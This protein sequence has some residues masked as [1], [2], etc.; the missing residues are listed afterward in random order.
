MNSIMKKIVFTFVM[1][2]LFWNMSRAQSEF[3]TTLHFETAKEVLSD[4]A[5]SHLKSIIDRWEG[6]DVYIEGHTDNRGTVKSNQ[7]LAEQRVAEVKA[8]LLKQ[9]INDKRIETKALGENQPLLPNTTAQNRAKNRRVVIHLKPSASMQAERVAKQQALINKRLLAMVDEESNHYTIQQSNQVQRI[10]ARQGTMVTIPARAFDVPVGT[11][12]NVKI[13]EVY[14]EADMVL[15]NLATI[16]NGKPLATGGMIK[17]E[18]FVGEKQI[19]LQKGKALEVAVPTDNPTSEMQLFDMESTTAGQTNWVNPQPLEIRREL[20]AEYID[21]EVRRNIKYEDFPLRGARPTFSGNLKPVDSVKI[22]KWKQ[23]KEAIANL[24]RNSHL[25]Y[26]NKNTLK[27]KKRI[28]IRPFDST[29][30]AA[31]IHKIVD[32]KDHK[33]QREKKRIARYYKNHKKYRN[34]LAA[35][36]QYKNWGANKDSIGH[37]NFQK[38][39][40]ARDIRAMNNY[41]QYLKNDEVITHWAAVYGL[42]KKAYQNWNAP[43]ISLER[44]EVL[45]QKAIKERD[46]FAI[47]LFGTEAY[48]EKFA[49]AIYQTTSLKEAYLAH[50]KYKSRLVDKDKAAELGMTVEEYYIYKNQKQALEEK[51]AYVFQLSNLGSFI[52][53]DYF[54]RMAPQELLVQATL[55]MP[56]Q[57]GATRTMMIFNNYKTVMNADNKVNKETTACSWN[58][59]PID[60][61]VKIVSVYMDKNEKLQVAIQSQRVNTN[62]ETLQYQTMNEQQFKTAL[63]SIN[64]L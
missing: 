50:Q 3:T 45:F 22:F 13:T 11:N 56:Q 14:Q 40:R 62:L 55:R 5:K 39:I 30:Y 32:K 28:R 19:A 51:T 15:Y 33:I 12:I 47:N 53:C 21:W 41:T 7:I 36:Q 35:L 64:K 10:I 9:G 57:V 26:K 49:Q 31:A 23:E 37:A 34:Y 16:S 42:S 43:R 59:V 44:D 58:N 17:I 38:A 1:L 60:E 52:N 25:N 54:P 46:T 20:F 24:P 18:A 2:S 29:D 63:R 61:P 4:S 27:G 6:Y 48:Q 8:L